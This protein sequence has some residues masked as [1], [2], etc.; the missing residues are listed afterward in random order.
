MA[1]SPTPSASQSSRSSEGPVERDTIPVLPDALKVRLHIRKGQPLTRCRVTKELP[2]TKTWEHRLGPDLQDSYGVFLE[3]IRQH[4][5]NTPSIDWPRDSV[6]YLQPTHSTPQKSYQR[7]DENSFDASIKKAWRAEAKRLNNPSQVFINIFV[8]VADRRATAAAAG[9][10]NTL[11][12]ATQARIQAATERLNASDLTLG[13]ITTRLFVRDLAQRDQPEGSL[14]V[15][16]N[17][18]FRQSQHLDREIDALNRRTE[19]ER[20]ESALEFRRVRVTLDVNVHDLRQ[21]L[22]LPG[23]NLN[24]LATADVA[25]AAALP[26]PQHDMP[27]VDHSDSDDN[28]S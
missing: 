20:T 3:R 24:G 26:R 13:P 21:V 5:Q 10:H 25:P 1:S 8:Y 28:N 14:V 11:Q 22:G 4:I 7:L 23:V 9:G 16:D 2:D 6:P 15:P 18:T 17:N 27:D 12:R 19:Q